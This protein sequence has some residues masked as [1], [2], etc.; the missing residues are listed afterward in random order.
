[1]K[2]TTRKAPFCVSL[3]KNTVALF[4]YPLCQKLSAKNLFRCQMSLY[5]SFNIQILHTSNSRG[6]TSLTLTVGLSRYPVYANS[7]ISIPFHY[8][9]K[10]A[11][12]IG[13]VEKPALYT[14]I[15]LSAGI[16]LICFLVA[17][18]VLCLELSVSVILITH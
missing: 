2:M 1:M 13:T 10:C 5:I 14:S 3:F 18:T 17:S 15:F 4:F 11:V 12:A 9:N 16:A 6:K 7:K 8:I